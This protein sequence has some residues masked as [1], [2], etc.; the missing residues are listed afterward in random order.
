V[1]AF[2]D[3]AEI[4]ADCPRGCSHEADAPECAMDAAVANGELA[5]VRL[6]SFRRMLR[7]G[8]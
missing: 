2:P 1:A 6:E 8:Q 3:L 7:S 4:T 5:P